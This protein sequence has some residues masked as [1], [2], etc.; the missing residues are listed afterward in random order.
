MILSGTRRRRK[1]CDRSGGFLG[2][3]GV[4]AFP[5]WVFLFKPLLGL[6]WACWTQAKA[7][8]GQNFCTLDVSEVLC[9]ELL[10]KGRCG[11]QPDL[12][13]FPMQM[14]KTSLRKVICTLQQLAT[15]AFHSYH[16]IALIFGR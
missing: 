2:A 12:G 14:L 16:G 4:T 13:A 6:P 8:V 3:Y 7:W 11:R 9:E 15:W 1:G 5:P 10:N